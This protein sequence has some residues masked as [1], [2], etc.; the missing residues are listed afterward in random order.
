ME[1]GLGEE[2]EMEEGRRE[3]DE[4]EEGL[5][6]GVLEEEDQYQSQR[7]RNFNEE[8][9]IK[10]VPKRKNWEERG[11]KNKMKKSSSPQPATSVLPALQVKKPPGP[12]ILKTSQP[13]GLPPVRRPALLVEDEEFLN[14]LLSPR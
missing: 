6:V 14:F 3:E 10:K 7:D 12:P 5:G 8:P 4:M 13:S 1:D 2:E 9:A 11:R